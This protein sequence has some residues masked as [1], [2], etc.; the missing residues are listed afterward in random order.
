MT[1]TYET[2]HEEITDTELQQL[3]EFRVLRTG[4]VLIFA[5]QAKDK[6]DSS[7]RHM[8]N[9]KGDFV[10]ASREEN[11]EKKLDVM[12]SGLEEMADGFVDMRLMLGSMTGIST[13]AGM[14]AERSNK[15]IQQVIRSNAKRR[16]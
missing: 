11:I 7:K 10:K 14:F 12:L 1:K 8:E 15:Q 5:K 2:L 9:A 3:N 16:K 13:A 6:G 4:A